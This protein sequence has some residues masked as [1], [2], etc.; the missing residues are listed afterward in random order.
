MLIKVRDTTGS[1]KNYIEDLIANTL[2]W[3]DSKAKEFK[4][5][6]FSATDAIQIGQFC[7]T[8]TR[9]KFCF[10]IQTPDHTVWVKLNQTSDAEGNIFY[11]DYEI[12]MSGTRDFFRGTIYG[13]E[14]KFWQTDFTTDLQDA[15]HYD[16]EKSK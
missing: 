1:V 3:F 15:I 10:S 5:Y 6:E 12:T 11:P 16:T 2:K 4:R 9:G 8:K 14:D 7:E 13:R